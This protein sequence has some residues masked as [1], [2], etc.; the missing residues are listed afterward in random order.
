[1]VV[2]P[3]REKKKKK[4]IENN[5]ENPFSYIVLWLETHFCK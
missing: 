4:K 3:A 2:E 5:K 1:V